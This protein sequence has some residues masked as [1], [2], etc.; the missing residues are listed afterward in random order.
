MDI[1]EQRRAE[2]RLELLKLANSGDNS[3]PEKVVDAAKAYEVFVFATA[4]D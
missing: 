2:L 3:T 4:Q 1:P